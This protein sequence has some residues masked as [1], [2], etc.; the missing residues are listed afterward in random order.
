MTVETSFT[1]LETGT[2]LGYSRKMSATFS[3]T[4]SILI[5]YV[6]SNP[7]WYGREG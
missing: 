1:I 5:A 2:S 7:D 3:F 6:T 4:S